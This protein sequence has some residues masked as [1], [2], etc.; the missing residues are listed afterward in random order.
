[1]PGPKESPQQSLTH[2]YFRNSNTRKEFGQRMARCCAS[3]IGVQIRKKI[4]RPR[5]PVLA[6]LSRF[7]CGV[8]S[9][10][11]RP[12]GH[13]HLRLFFLDL[14]ALFLGERFDF[15]ALDFFLAGICVSS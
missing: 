6:G 7:V 14:L 11:I 2:L 13:Y 10:K 5:T 15:L 8:E 3:P 1:M 12:H 9:R 4:D